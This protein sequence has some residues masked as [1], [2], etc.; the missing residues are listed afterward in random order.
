MKR[1]WKFVAGSLILL[2]SLCFSLGCS[3]DTILRDIPVGER[4]EKVLHTDVVVVGSGG[5]GMTAALVAAQGGLD[6]IVIEQMFHT[7]GN[8]ILAGG[9]HNFVRTD[10]THAVIN[11]AGNRSNATGR[12]Q[13]LAMV[14]RM[15]DMSVFESQFDWIFAELPAGSRNTANTAMQTW[16]AGLQGHWDAFVAHHSVD[17]SPG[18]D[19]PFPLFDSIYLHSLNTFYGGDFAGIPELV[20][21][22]SIN[23]LPGTN[24]LHSV[25]MRWGSF[26]D[27]H[28]IGNNPIPTSPTFPLHP[29]NLTGSLYHRNWWVH[30]AEE[31]Q[32]YPTPTPRR[33]GAGYIKPQEARFRQAAHGPAH[34]IPPGTNTEILLGHRGEGIIMK[35][36][37]VAGVYGTFPDGTFR[38]YADAVLVA[39][40]GF[41]ANWDM[42]ERFQP[43]AL[44]VYAPAR[45][46]TTTHP[47][48]IPQLRAQPANAARKWANLREFNTT[49]DKGAADGRFI[50]AV[51]R[52]TGARLYHMDQIQLLP[53]LGATN[54]FIDEM[55]NR[56]V[57]ENG[58][59]DQ[60]A[61]AFIGQRAEGRWLYSVGRANLV[62]DGADPN[63]RAYDR[64]LARNLGARILNHSRGWGFTTTGGAAQLTVTTTAEQLTALLSSAQN[65]LVNQFADNFIAEV[66][67]Y[68]ERARAGV[69]CW[70][71][72]TV[73]GTVNS[74]QQ[75][76]QADGWGGANTVT[77]PNIHHT[78]GGLLINDKTQV[79][80]TNGN[81]IPGL[82]AA[83]EAIGG[84]HARNRL[85]GNALTDIIAFG[86]IM[87]NQTRIFFDRPPAEF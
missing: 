18:A 25:G 57:N 30:A 83:G 7:G 33:P 28:N 6:V 31:D 65:D 41:G 39:T 58:R 55:G 64:H 38:I 56:T 43:N 85:G 80:H 13:S 15:L 51:E 62:G 67:H 24:W 81:V 5:A 84:L 9:A 48:P 53:S 45:V 4:V 63:H 1:N 78:M 22:M 14:R 19:A 73:R 61:K 34:G 35:D 76:P 47:A 20:H 70:T 59:R 2:V 40:G 87:G 54:L 36:G 68:N 12:T 74:G 46:A 26:N 29:S 60:G 27:N 10:N 32:D 16:Q 44:S 17:L 77:R 49:N 23:G 21:I 50:L 69:A 66:W 79:I 11:H 82:F 3:G 75:G 71:G 52:D 37:R 42:L 8:T 86:F 72:K